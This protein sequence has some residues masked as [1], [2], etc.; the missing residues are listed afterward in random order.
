MNLILTLVV[1]AALALLWL[2]YDK[3]TR[4]GAI[5]LQ[6]AARDFTTWFGLASIALAD[7]IVQLLQWVAGFWEPLQAHV[8]PVLSSAG[9]P[10]FLVAWGALMLAL[11]FKAQKPLPAVNLPSFPDP[12]DQA[13]A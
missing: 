7:W 4:R 8:G 9:S 3:F 10:T 12:T 2:F 6:K 5:P 13:G 1:L 11:K